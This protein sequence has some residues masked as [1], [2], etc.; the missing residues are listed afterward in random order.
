MY[1]RA[2]VRLE[3]LDQQLRAWND[4]AKGA[5]ADVLQGLRVRMQQICV[6]IPDT[7][8]ARHSCDAFLK[9]AA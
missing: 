4:A 9:A 8:A 1:S 7:E 6:K 5:H 2:R 3:R